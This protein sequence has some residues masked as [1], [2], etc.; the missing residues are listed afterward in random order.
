MALLLFFAFLSGVV[1][2]FA[3]C[4]WPIL[5]VILSAGVSGGDRKP[6]GV[7][8]GLMVSFTF[9]T[10]TLSYLLKI[11]PIDPDA[12]R[13]FAVVVI[14]L[15]GLFLAVPILGR[16]L[17]A[18]ASR[19][20][21]LG[22]LSKVG[23]GFKGGFVTGFA[24]G[25]IWSPCAGPILATVA[26]LAATQSLTLAIV[27][28]AVAFV[29]GVGLPLLILAILGQRILNRTRRLSP[30]T[31]R[32]QQFFGV[33]M[34]LAALAIYTGYD[35]VLQTRFANFCS[36]N[37]IT[38]LERFQT[39]AIVTE[40]LATLRNPEKNNLLPAP[41]IR[42]SV[43]VSSGLEDLGPAPEF[44]GIINWLNIDHPLTLR[45]LRGKVVLVDFWTYSCI[46]CIRTLPYVTAWY[47]RYKDRGFVVVGVHTPEFE[48]EKKTANV[49]DA[50]EKHRITYPVAQD[51][52][53]ATWK[54]YDNQ[55][56]PAFYLI[57][58]NGFLRR[59]HFGEGDYNEMEAAIQ[60]LLQESG[61]PAD[62]SE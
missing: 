43:E 14:S 50:I 11:L 45:E 35:Q 34:I 51:N 23:R 55:Y 15:L 8:A 20:S 2:I 47:E 38:F 40:Q 4:I 9:F 1:T 58:A 52:D 36:A 27:L 29:A 19:F 33:V 25:L 39:N 56:W 57:D 21:G 41:S 12:L 24:L 61:Q 49:A 10:L 7:V 31:G 26:T 59:V 54:A 46:N 37:G 30:Y 28:V 3:P 13:F 32:I 17:E 48:V 44:A 6:F 42:K 18:V 16:Y 5:P 60:S 62:K 22:S 53:Y